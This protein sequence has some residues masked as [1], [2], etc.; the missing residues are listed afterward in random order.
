MTTM[1]QEQLKIIAAALQKA[2]SEAVCQ[3]PIDEKQGR[4]IYHSNCMRRSQSVYINALHELDDFIL[5]LT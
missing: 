2:K 5:H 3:C 1:Q 4:V